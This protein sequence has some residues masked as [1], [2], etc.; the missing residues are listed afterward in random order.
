MNTRHVAL[1]ILG[2]AV[3]LGARSAASRHD[4]SP[5][6]PALLDTLEQL[7]RASWKAWQAR[8]SG[9]FRRF[10]SDDHVEIGFRGPSG[11]NVVVSGVGSRGC[12]VRSYSVDHF[13]VTRFAPTVALLT[14]HAA[15]NTTCGGTAV[16][17]PVWVGSLFL[18]RAGRWVN[19][20]YQQSQAAPDSR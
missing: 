4:Q 20:A 7:E 1:L 14:Y 15:Q 6:P 10:L 9:F 5:N 18:L 16:P 8:D 2:V 13:A 19:A 3:L 12:V 17:S 11:K